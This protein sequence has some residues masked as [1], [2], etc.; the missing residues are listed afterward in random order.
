[1]NKFILLI[2]LILSQRQREYIKKLIKRSTPT[3]IKNVYGF[4]IYQNINDLDYSKYIGVSLE[5][6][7]RTRDSDVLVIAKFFLKEG[8]VAVDIGANIGLMSLAMS[9]FVGAS[10]AVVSIEPGP[11]SFGLLRA[12]K[13]VNKCSNIT[14]VDAAV[15]DEDV[16][17]PL[18]INPNGESDNQVHKGVSSYNFKNEHLREMHVVKGISLD[19]KL[20]DYCNVN[21]IRFIKIDTQGHEWHVLKGGRKLLKKIESLAILCEFAPYLKAWDII[22]VSTFF[23][24]ILDLNFSVYDISDIKHG[25]INLSYLEDHYGSDKVGKYTDLLLIKGE[26]LLKFEKER[27]YLL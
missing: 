27:E 24:L 21:A 23:Q 18:F 19:N 16:D 5:E 22:D 14:L 13:F 2:K 11:I 6:I 20:S 1:M 12:N 15:S 10:G 9:Q 3:F 4:D 25:K 17:V 7:N 26:A 8:D